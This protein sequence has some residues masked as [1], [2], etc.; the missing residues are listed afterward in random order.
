MEPEEKI[1][2]DWRV[3]TAHAGKYIL[4]RIQG[5]L[6]GREVMTSEVIELVHEDENWE[7]LFVRTR[8]GS[9]YRLGTRHRPEEIDTL[10]SMFP[11]Q[12]SIQA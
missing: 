11:K 3:V 2:N 7:R 5:D 6:S 8:S 4:L 1:I 12:L 10:A 9:R